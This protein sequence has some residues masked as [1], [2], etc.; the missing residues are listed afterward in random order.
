MEKII[1]PIAKLISEPILIFILCILGLLGYIIYSLLN[2]IKSQVDYERELISEL[3]SN[4]K[5]LERL[6]TLIETLVQ[7]RRRE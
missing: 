6:T 4:T 2:T 5:T 1:L 7:G 3:G